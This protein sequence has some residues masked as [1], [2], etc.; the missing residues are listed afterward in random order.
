[1][2]RTPNPPTYLAW[3][4][5]QDFRCPWVRI[6]AAWPHHDGKGFGL[7]L[8]VLPPQPGRIQL[9]LHEP[10]PAAEGDRA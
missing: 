2:T 8:D 5:P 6:G 9:R 4:V 1:M 7:S 3:Y 10:K